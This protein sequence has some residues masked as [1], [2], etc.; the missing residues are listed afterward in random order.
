MDEVAR[1]NIPCMRDL[2]VTRVNLCA[3]PPR[4]TNFF[5][6]I[7]ERDNGPGRGFVQ[8]ITQMESAGYLRPD[9]DELKAR[10]NTVF[11]FTLSFPFI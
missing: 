5:L 10:W 1:L 4:I 8:I 2:C 9:E 6:Q 11:V 7:Q 3:R